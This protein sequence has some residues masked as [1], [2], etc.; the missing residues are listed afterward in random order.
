MFNK[1]TTKDTQ[2]SKGVAVSMLIFH[3]LFWDVSGYGIEINGFY[4]SQQIGI[5]AKVCVSI[6]LILSGFGLNE[7]AKKHF[8]LKFF[9]KK[10]LFNLYINYWFIFFS[11]LL[12][13]TIFFRSETLAMLSGA[14]PIAM[15][16]L[17][18]SGLH[19]F[20]YIPGYNGAWW[21]ITLLLLLYAVFPILR[22]M[23]TTYNHL[24][25]LMIAVVL[26]TNLIPTGF[27]NTQYIVPYIF[28]FSFGIYISHNRLFERITSLVYRVNNFYKWLIGLGLLLLLLVLCYYRQFI[29]QNIYG[30]RFD[31]MF[32][33]II[34][35]IN[36]L[37][38][39]RIKTLNIMMRFLGK[40]SL[41]IF[42]THMFLTHYFISDFV[43]QLKY[44]VV[45]FFFVTGVSAILA[46]FAEKIKN[47]I[48]LNKKR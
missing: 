38:L 18:L 12:L 4:L 25:L 5:I 23:I 11:F 15:F 8:D 13:G 2:F 26:F 21:Y 1:F 43:Y 10:R 22:K 40:Y 24:A 31:V 33:F 14:H 19:Y 28:H 6:F 32:G 17:N 36:K 39:A 3:H 41:D 35:I 34:I 47:I 27:L 48:G 45:M 20:V 7:S 37:Y 46:V 9:L 29:G 44:P 42:L 16:L 30:M